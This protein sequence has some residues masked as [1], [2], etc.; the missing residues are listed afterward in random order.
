MNEWVVKDQLSL[1]SLIHFN[2]TT[3]IYIYPYPHHISV[4][5]LCIHIQVLKYLSNPPLIPH[6][7]H[8]LVY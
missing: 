3:L 5:Q 6:S 7:R 8:D 2:V 1:H 4:N